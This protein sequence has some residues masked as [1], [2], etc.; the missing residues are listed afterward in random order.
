MGNFNVRTT[1]DE[2]WLTP[3]EII[4]A[5]G[6]FDLDPCSPIDRPWDTATT[7]YNKLMDGLNR[8]WKG[9]V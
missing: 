9:R 5:L 6:K 4:K 2:Q 8:E 7:Y 3:P 1:D